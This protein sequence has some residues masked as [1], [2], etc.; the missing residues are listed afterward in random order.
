MSREADEALAK[1]LLPFV[2]VVFGSNGKGGSGTC[3]ELADGSIAVLTAKH[4]VL[5]CLRNTGHVGIGAYNVRYQEADLIRMDSSQDGDAAYLEF[6]KRP[7][8]VKAVPFAEWTMTRPDLAAGQRVIAVGFPGAL[9]RR[10]GNRMIPN[11]AWLRDRIH[12]VERNRV[13]SGLNEREEG[14]PPTLGGLSGAG[15]FSD[16]GKFIGVVVEEKRRI[17]ETRGELYTLLPSEF[18]EL[19]TPFTYPQSSA[20]PFHVE[21]QALRM[22]LLRPDG[23]GIL[24]IVGV[25]VEYAWSTK[26]PAFKHGRLYSLEFIIPGIDRHYPININSH[27][28]WD[29]DTE[30]DQAKAAQEAFKWLLLRM[31][32]LLDDADSE[33]MT[34]EVRAAT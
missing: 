26:D 29:G 11:P 32:W 21:N 18:G 1:E 19:Y 22:T 28:T 30:E 6:K 27:F 25:L 24:A 4:V 16:D 9:R 20:G 34:I 3:V 14:V 7:T 5:E 13:V 31:R 10:E 12:A 8:T 17:T 15:L 2:A 33:N 23:Q